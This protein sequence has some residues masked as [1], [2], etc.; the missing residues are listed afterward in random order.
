MMPGMDGIET[1]E[2]LE[3]DPI[4]RN[5]PIIFLTSLISKKEEK[6]GIYI[7]DRRCMSKPYNSE[8]LLSEIEKYF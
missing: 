8:E 6:D 7:L 4:T 3:K 1:A 2:G 5:I